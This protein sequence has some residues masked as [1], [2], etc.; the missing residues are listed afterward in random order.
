MKTPLTHLSRFLA[1]G[2][3][4][5]AVSSQ[6]VVVKV[7]S[8]KSWQ[9][10]NNVVQTNGFAGYVFG[11]AWA[12]ADLRARFIPT[13]SPTGWPFSTAG[14]QSPNTNTYNPADSFWNYPDGT[15]NKLIEAN[16]YVDVF[17]NFGGQP[18]TFQGTVISNSIPLASLDGLPTVTPSSS[19]HVVAFIKEFTSG[20]GF[21]G[22][23]TTTNLS[24][25]AF[26]VSRTMGASSVCQYGF[27][28]FGPN[29]AP[30]SANALS[31]LGLVVEDSD[32]AI[33]TQPTPKTVTTGSSVSLTVAAVGGTPLS[34]QWQ[35]YGTNLSNGG[36]ISGVTTTN[37]VIANAQ[38]TDSGPYTVIVTDAA[39]SATSS[40]AQVTVLD[41]VIVTPPH[42][43]RVEQNST[44]VFS[45]AAT[46]ASPITY[47]WKSV[48]GGV[49][50]NLV[51]G[52]NVSGATTSTVTL[53]NVQ[54][55]SSGIYLVTL[56]TGSGSA[57]AGATLVVKSFADFSNFLEN[58]GFENDPAG[59][60]ESPWSRFQ[61]TDPSF[62][63][64]QDANDTYFGG[65]NV[66]IHA[67]T[68]VSYT[69]FAAEYSGIFQDVPASPGQIFTADMWFYNAT[70]D[71]VPGPSTSSTNESFLEVQFRAGANVLQQY[72]T[73]IINYT[74][75]R[76]V[77]INLPA[78]NA[79]GFG[80]MPPSSNA[81]YL[82]APPGTTLV[83][84]QV[85]MHDIANSS[86]FGSLYYDSASLM[87]KIPVALTVKPSGDN[88]ELSWKTQGSTSYQVQY[89][90]DLNAPTWTNLEVVT[91]T[92]LVVTKS[93][94]RTPA[95]RIYRVLTL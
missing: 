11:A 13:N 69:T 51:N 59:L 71:P 83:R 94:A 30:G 35:R 53:S 20:Y 77:W 76:D 2:L 34:Y 19:W 27:Y 95:G 6:A 8:T 62:G 85:T 80:S 26:S 65:G 39:S 47:Q 17:T 48:I 86:G 92:G 58:P 49:T 21:I 60:N 64:F 28:V 37:L 44:V 15:P 68:Y 29:A 66:N 4:A 67:G 38:T 3:V 56:S 36:N 73:P 24:P 87:L 42:N 46:S 40:V 14:I 45:V 33:T 9:G 72:I 1:L 91:G 52:A 84:F 41:I 7:D 12:T 25:G 88:V 78:T 63:S 57:D 89:K 10:F 93:Y 70:G 18:V 22:I 54:V 5:A 55:S 23:T 16:W 75:P 61:T 50:N 79:G 82:V 32:P 90:T 81:K 31:G 43:Q 74:M